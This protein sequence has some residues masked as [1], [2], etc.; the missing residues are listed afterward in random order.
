MK[1][2]EFKVPEFIKED[3]YRKLISVFFACLIWYFVHQHVSEV[4]TF[5]NVKVDVIAE[6]TGQVFVSNYKPEIS[7]ELRGPRKILNNLESKDI[8]VSIN[9]KE[10]LRPG[11]NEI[12]VLEDH[13]KLPAGLK[14]ESILT[15]AINVN[16]DTIVEKEVDVKVRYTNRLSDKYALLREPTVKPERVIIT[17]PSR[18]L[19]KINYIDTRSIYIDPSRTTDFSV[20]TK[21]VPPEGVTLNY[22]NVTAYVELK[23]RIEFKSLPVQSV[24]VLYTNSS[25]EAVKIE[26]VG[27]AFAYVSGP[28]NV[29]ENLDVDKDVRLFI[30]ISDPNVR[31]YE[32]KF[33]CNDPGVSKV[34]IT[35]SKVTLSDL[36]PKE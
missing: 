2:F 3:F 31:T 17:G 1:L 16:V 36:P 10:L 26:P 23:K 24:H 14:I 27:Q 18:R 29:L 9:V 8:Q 5:K 4:E 28:P 33:W 32:I 12:R 20:T 11:P 13:I 21:V 25:K 15:K 30:E 22:D 35:P 6:N 34:K 19:E 7:V